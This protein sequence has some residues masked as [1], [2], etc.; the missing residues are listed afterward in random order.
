VLSFA[1]SASW[2]FVTAR[3]EMVLA[4]LGARRLGLGAASG[5]VTFLTAPAAAT[6]ARLPQGTLNFEGLESQVDFSCSD[7]L[8]GLSVAVCEGDLNKI[9]RVAIFLDPPGHHG[10]VGRPRLTVEILLQTC[11]WNPFVDH[12]NNGFCRPRGSPNHFG[13]TGEGLKLVH[14]MLW[15]FDASITRFHWEKGEGSSEHLDLLLQLRGRNG[16]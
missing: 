4:A 12:D 3:R 14:D 2:I 5:E 13:E 1:V 9:G 11:R 15:R 10:R 7:K 16:N 8:L 6:L